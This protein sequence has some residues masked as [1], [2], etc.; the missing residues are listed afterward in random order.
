MRAMSYVVRPV[1]SAAE[2]AGVLRA[3]GGQR[4]SSR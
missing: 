3:C 1:E 2:F 4:L